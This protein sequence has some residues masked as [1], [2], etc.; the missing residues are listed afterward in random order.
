M[1]FAVWFLLGVVALGFFLW[2]LEDMIGLHVTDR[3]GRALAVLF[4][5]AVLGGLAYGIVTAFVGDQGGNQSA[6]P[7]RGECFPN[8]PAPC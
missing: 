1:P 7:E 2:L 4:L 3:L 5:L 6:L 8:G